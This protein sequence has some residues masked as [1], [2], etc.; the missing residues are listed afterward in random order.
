MDRPAREGFCNQ[1]ASDSIG[2]CEALRELTC[3]G[4][5][6]LTALPDALGRLQ[7]LEALGITA[8]EA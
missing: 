3:R 6:A 2:D 4:C 5:V 7:K 8:A 1:T